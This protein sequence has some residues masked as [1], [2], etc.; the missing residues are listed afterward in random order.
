MY[1][2]IQCVFGVHGIEAHVDDGPIDYGKG[3]LYAYIYIP[4]ILHIY[5]YV[6]IYTYI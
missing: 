4:L 5:I 3:L 6:R 1:A 2:Y